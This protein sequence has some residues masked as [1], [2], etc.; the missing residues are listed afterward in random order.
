[1]DEQ[2]EIAAVADRAEIADAPGMVLDVDLAR[3]LEDQ[4]VPAPRATR[5]RA[6]PQAGSEVLGT[7]MGVGEEARVGHLLGSRGREHTHTC[8]GFVDHARDHLGTALVAAQIAEPADPKRLCHQSVPGQKWP[9]TES[10]QSRHV[11]CYRRPE[12]IRLRR[13]AAPEMCASRSRVRGS[14]RPHP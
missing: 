7:E 4:D 8:A 2:P 11:R 12:S 13:I 5:Q 6:L 10:Q 14:V 9:G 1:M 3:I